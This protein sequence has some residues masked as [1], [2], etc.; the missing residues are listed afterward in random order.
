MLRKYKISAIISLL[1]GM[2]SFSWIIYDYIAF[3]YLRPNIESFQQLN[4]I[5]QTVAIF[6]WLGYLVLI[7]FHIAS[8][9]SLVFYFQTAKKT[10]FFTISVLI[11][12]LLSFIALIGDFGLLHD[13][14]KEGTDAAA[15][16]FLL[17]MVLAFHLLFCL[18]MIAQLFFSLHRLKI[19]DVSEIAVK[20]EII[21]LIAQWVG[22]ICGT[23]GL[24]FIIMSIKMI[25]PIY[26]LHYLI[27]FYCPFIIF[28]YGLVAFY[29][30]LIKV[31]EKPSQW[32][33]EKQWQDITRS[34]LITMVLS[35]PIM[36]L[37]Y[38]VGYGIPYNPITMLWFPFYLFLV[39][40]IF[41]LSTLYFSKN[42][43]EI[44][45][46]ELLNRMIK[47]KMI[48]FFIIVILVIVIFI[49]PYFEQKQKSNIQSDSIST[50]HPDTNSVFNE[51]ADQTLIIQLR[52]LPEEATKLEMVLIKPGTFFMGS[53]EDEQGR[54]E[55]DWPPHKVIIT[56][57]FYMGKYEVTQAQWEAVLGKRSHRSK[58]TGMNR[59]V[60]KVSWIQCWRFIRE[61][62][63]LGQGTFR[64]PTE[65]E[66]EYACRAGTTTRFF[67][68]NALEC[69]DKGIVSCEEVDQYICWAG[70]MDLMEIKDVGT[71]LPN[72]WG[73]YDMQGN[74]SEWCLDQW[75][76]PYQREM[77]I[78][79][80]GPYYNK[81]PFVWTNRVFR[82][83][84]AFHGKKI[85]RGLMDFRS[86]SRF[87]EQSF[88]FHYSLGFRLVREY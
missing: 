79:P 6:I 30:L 76:D 73:L 20:D 27:P 41:S 67:F 70:N 62:N 82:G 26:I 52:N 77:Q 60:G 21:F 2:L 32:Y 11:L 68:G 22:I 53:P 58:F 87:Y 37:L 66:W 78:D 63:K 36:A 19:E 65:A 56:K 15:E 23:V 64:L 33:D 10:N 40:F 17:Y 47:N 24:V 44:G 18:S 29:W 71:K 3:S 50:M 45:V 48:W 1:L 72:P 31:K 16:W 84:S 59:P 86:A 42:I 39:L 74:V 69:P 54:D 8:F 85:M 35:I 14:A 57:P 34:A 28:P 9:I 13:I 4:N 81:F 7:L 12:A 55:D 49:F 80:K 38:L 88:D 43:N 51:L 83:G 75:E 5:E 61:L 25:I 46:I